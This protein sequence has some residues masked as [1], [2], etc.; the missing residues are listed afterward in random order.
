MH[1][2]SRFFCYLFLI[3]NLVSVG[4]LAEEGGEE[5][6]EPKG[7]AGGGFI[8]KDEYLELNSS[9]EQLNAKIKAKKETLKKLL[10][11]KDH[12]KD[13]EAFKEI[14]KQIETEYRELKE[15][16]ENVEKKKAMLR[17]RFPERSFKKQEETANKIQRLE[18]MGTEALIEKEM[19]QL[20]NIAEK[21]Y[22]QK[23]RMK[24]NAEQHRREPAQ[25]HGITPLNQNPEDFSKALILKK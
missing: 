11:D 17:Y 4:V 13:P 25:E 12:V 8:K 10:L 3:T 15:T 16:Q 18:E 23:V 21:Q 2:V 24:T 20:L 7:E 1:F 6:E 14:V 5:K 19:D 22:Q 9:V